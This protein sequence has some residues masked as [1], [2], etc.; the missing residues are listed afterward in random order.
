MMV[1]GAFLIIFGVIFAVVSITSFIVAFD[2]GWSAFWI[3]VAFSCLTGLLFWGG[4]RLYTYGEQQEEQVQKA[5]T[6][7]DENLV[8]PDLS[9]P[10]TDTN[11]TGAA[12]SNIEDS[13]VEI[14]CR[15]GV[16]IVIVTNVGPYVR[17]HTDGKPY[18]C[19][20]SKDPSQ[21]LKS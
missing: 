12:P 11:A 1:L 6:D 20:E 21:E 3:G 8:A 4:H 13:D 15:D 19:S 18:T 5:E 16:Q 9:A 14:K 17:L 10:T 2:A 7:V